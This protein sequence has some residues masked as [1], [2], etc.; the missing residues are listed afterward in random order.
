MDAQR[1]IEARILAQHRVIAERLRARPRAVLALAR[2]NLERWSGNY[3]DEPVPA[4]LSEWRGLLEGPLPELLELLT[5]GS[6]DAVRLRSSS[7]FAGVLSARER[8]QIL[9]ALDRETP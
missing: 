7:P 6:E 1:R 2:A 9:E 5:A 8:W 3:R 4:W